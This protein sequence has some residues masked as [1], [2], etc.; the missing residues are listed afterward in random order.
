MKQRCGR[1]GMKA[2]WRILTKTI[3]RLL[4][5]ICPPHAGKR[6]AIPVLM[7]LVSLALCRTTLAQAVSTMPLPQ[8]VESSAPLS[9]WS[10]I[11]SSADGSKLV[12]CSSVDG[13]YASSDSGATW[14]RSSAAP[15]AAWNSLAGSADGLRWIAGADSSP[16]Y[17]SRDGGGTWQA[18]GSPLNSWISVASSEDGNRLL[19]AT[20]GAIY[21]SSDAGDHWIQTD[22]PARPW[23]QIVCSADG[24]RW[25]ALMSPTY[26]DNDQ[27]V[28]PISIYASTDLGATWTWVKALDSDSSWATAA[29][30]AD[31]TTIVVGMAGGSSSDV[32]GGG[33][34]ITS[35]DGGGTWNMASV[36]EPVVSVAVSADGARL[37]AA[38]SW[39]NPAVG[40]VYRYSDGGKTWLSNDETYRPWQAVTCSAD[41]LK[42]AAAASPFGGGFGPIPP[43]LG[44]IYTAT[45]PAPMSVTTRGG[46]LILHWPAWAIGYDLQECTDFKAGIWSGIQARPD[47]DGV[48]ASVTLPLESASGA[49]FFRLV[50]P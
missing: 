10:A 44:G 29:L 40:H 17:L 28:E 46:S 15:N 25:V 9:F 45:T 48:T 26:D 34:I 23:S 37:F 4:T 41:G 3:T 32:G 31:G 19:A 38:T 5:L 14:R 50:Q 36:P 39:W 27:I 35:S 47:S 24:S 22:A 1:D 6:S 8:W 42:V 43:V 11:A 16:I 18:T 13:L 21:F 30:T 33:R 20:D 49:R 7:L 12:A 2:H